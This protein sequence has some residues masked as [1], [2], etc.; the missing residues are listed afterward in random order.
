MVGTAGNAVLVEF[1]SAVE[2]VLRHVHQE[3]LAVRNSERNDDKADVALAAA[4]LEAE[5]FEG[6]QSS[7]IARHLPT[8]KVLL[9]CGADFRDHGG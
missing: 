4:F 8:L 7:T 2:A 6:C 1:S 3:D 5:F 9:A